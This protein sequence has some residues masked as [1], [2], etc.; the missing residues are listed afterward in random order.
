MNLQIKKRAKHLTDRFM[1]LLNS[2]LLGFALGNSTPEEWED[3]QKSSFDRAKKPAD[4]AAIL[5][6]ASFVM[7]LCQF[8]S[9]MSKAEDFWLLSIVLGV[10]AMLCFGLYFYILLGL[11]NVITVYF[12]KD[13]SYHSSRLQKILII[14]ISLA[15]VASVAYGI[16]VFVS[17]FVS[18]SN[19][20]H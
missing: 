4:F 3:M 12:L 15:L 5:I 14:L 10:N 17:T 6:R 18:V 7:L 1:R 2:T 16:N 8:F 19:L 20:P 13:T 11:F 9:Y